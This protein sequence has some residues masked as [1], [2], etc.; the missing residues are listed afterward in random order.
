MLPRA[1][2]TPFH[3]RSPTTVLS[4]FSGVLISS[5]LYSLHDRWM[6]MRQM[7][8]QFFCL[9]AQRS[10]MHGTYGRNFLHVV[11]GTDENMSYY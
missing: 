6:D 9:G 10:E 2:L 3:Q 7:I 8:Y 5:S 4:Q 11:Q 1:D